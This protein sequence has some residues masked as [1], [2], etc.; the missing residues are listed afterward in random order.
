MVDLEPLKFSLQRYQT[1]L[2]CVDDPKNLISIKQ[3]L[4]ILSARDAR[5][6][7]IETSQLKQYQVIHFATHGILNTEYPELSG[8]VF[9]LVDEKGNPINGFLRLHEIFNLE[10]NANLVVISACETGLG[11]EIKGEGL[12]GLTRGF[13]YAGSP[14]ILVSLWK[15]SDA[16]TS[17]M[18]QR[19]YR[20]LWEEKLSPAIALRQA[21]LEMQ[22]ETPWVSPYYWSAFVL[23]GDWQ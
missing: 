22:T 19:F 8:V 16:A 18:M 3:V 10:L 1:A 15:V 2:E 13:M 5:Q 12:V 17:E 4:E 6:K 9:S 7:S 20:L 14:R 11:K 23:Q 21:Q